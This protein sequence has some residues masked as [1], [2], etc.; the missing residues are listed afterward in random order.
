MAFLFNLLT[1]L[2]VAAISIQVTLALEFMD[3]GTL[4]NDGAH[5][6][7]EESSAE[8][9]GILTGYTRDTVAHFNPR[10]V[11]AGFRQLWERVPLQKIDVIKRR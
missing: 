5:H 7:D 11:D 1:L 4:G 2:A 3:E 6:F 9:P 10:K 8:V